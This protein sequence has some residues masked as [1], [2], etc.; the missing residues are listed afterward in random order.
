MAY[1]FAFTRLGGLAF[2]MP[3]ISDSVVKVR[4]RALFVVMTSGC[5]FPFIGALPA[6]VY[7]Q[8]SFL[9]L[10]FGQEFLIGAFLGLTGRIIMS[11]FDLAGALIGYQMNLANA[12]TEGI[13]SNQQVALPGAFLSMVAVV[14]IFVTDIHHVFLTGILESYNI[15]QVGAPILGSAL[16]SDLSTSFLKTIHHSFILAIQIASP[17]LI[18][19]LITQFAG[20][21]LNRLMPQVQIFFILQPFQ[22]LMGIAVLVLSLQ[23]V[24]PHFLESFYGI[25]SSLWQYEV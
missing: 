24:I 6:S 18:I 15:F 5:I 4:V 21:V 25:I 12:F 1:L 2:Y 10:I 3:G 11:A 19:G 22:I 13:A 9:I 23:F 7:E 20:G 8:S 14:L 16:G 17:V